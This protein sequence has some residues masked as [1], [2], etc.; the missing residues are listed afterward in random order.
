[1]NDNPAT[2]YA[3]WFSKAGYYMADADGHLKL[4]PTEFEAHVAGTDLCGAT[5]I[6]PFE[7]HSRL[8][9]TITPWQRVPDSM[10]G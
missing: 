1:M 4:F 9:Y 8:N 2:E 3:V 10:D 6:V 7:V 5:E